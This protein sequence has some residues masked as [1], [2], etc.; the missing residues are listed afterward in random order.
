MGRTVT[1]TKTES[2]RRRPFGWR[3][4]RTLSWFQWTLIAVGVGLI[5]VFVIARLVGRL[6]G[7]AEI[8]RFEEARAAR[9]TAPI[10]TAASA[11]PSPAAGFEVHHPVD[12]SLWADGRVREYEESLT[13]DVG[14]PLALLRIPKLGL[15]VAVL[16]GTSELAL[17][18]GVG[19]IDGT[20]RPGDAGN[21]GI[22][23]H[24]DGFFRG[25]KDI[26]LG[27]ALELETLSGVARYEVAETFIVDPTDVHVLDPTDRPAVTLVTCYPFYFVGSAPQRFIVRATIVE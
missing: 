16:E 2:G 11:T 24:R 17:N 18:R 12:M 26:A 4:D 1:T 8:R 22:A 20:P 15:E 14:I 27:D 6:G 21:I 9:T 19:H 3:R 13:Q 25:L 23:G 5:A 10:P 7:D